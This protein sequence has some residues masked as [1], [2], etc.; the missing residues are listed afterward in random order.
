VDDYLINLHNYPALDPAKQPDAT[1]WHLYD[2]GRKV[3]DFATSINFS[4]INNLIAAVG[5][6][7]IDL[8]LD[9][10]KRYDASIDHYRAIVEDLVKKAMSY[11]RDFILPHKQY[12]APTAAEKEMLQNLQTQ[13]RNFD[14]EDEKELQTL[15]FTVARSF[16]VEP[17]AFFK[18]FYELL[19][20]QE[21]G[22]RFGTFVR[23]VGKE[24]ALA[25]LDEAAK[26][27]P[28]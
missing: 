21:R 8:I 24:R 25:M 20:G 13:L 4:L 7:N 1:I 14:S 16:G 18:A 3:P 22:P 12:R 15:P 10:L 11:Y 23:L 28:T 26:R 19:F 5:D 6:D 9:Y 2:R 17:K 27:Q